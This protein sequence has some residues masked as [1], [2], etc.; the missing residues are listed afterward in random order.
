MLVF[1]YSLDLC[2]KYHNILNSVKV[3]NDNEYIPE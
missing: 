1:E 2:N 3:E